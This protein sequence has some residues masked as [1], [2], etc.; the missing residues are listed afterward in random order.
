M[1]DEKKWEM[2]FNFSFTI[3]QKLDAMS[4]SLKEL[5]NLKKDVEKVKD[6]V[7]EVKTDVSKNKGDIDLLK[8]ELAAVKSD[9]QKE[10][11]NR[12]KYRVLDGIKA[13]ERNLIIGNL[14]ESNWEDR[15]KTYATLRDFLRELFD[16]EFM[17]DEKNWIDPSHFIIEDAHRLPSNPLNFTTSKAEGKRRSLIFRCQTVLERNI[18]LKRCKYLSKYNEGKTGRDVVYIKRHYPQ[19]IQD[20]EKALRPRFNELRKQGKN[21]RME[22]DFLT[23]NMKIVEKTTKKD[24]NVADS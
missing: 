14:P 19:E 23:A 20:Q 21:V 5:G 15:A 2:F 11:D 4:D 24:Q 6:D 17:A 13:R 8:T 3:N 12:R 9:L 18:I 10:R 1:T 7:K 22:I 16:F